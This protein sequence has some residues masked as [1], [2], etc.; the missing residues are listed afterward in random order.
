MIVKREA[1]K[2]KSY[3]DDK[4]RRCFEQRIINSVEANG[5]D[6]E[7]NNGRKHK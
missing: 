2:W 6:L 5:G 7:E 4:M 3:E 1:T